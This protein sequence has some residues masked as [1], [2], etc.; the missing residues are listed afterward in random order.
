MLTGVFAV[1]VIDSTDLALARTGLQSLADGAA[2][3]GAQSF[4]PGSVSSTAAGFSVTLTT[5]SVSTAVRSYLKDSAV[6]G[7]TVKS[8]IVPDA[9]TSVVTL[10]QTWEPPFVSEFLPLRVR[11][12]ATARARTRLG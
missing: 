9:H 10:A 1:S 5:R 2:L 12:T 3:A 4:T 8:I 11:L 6:T 7:V